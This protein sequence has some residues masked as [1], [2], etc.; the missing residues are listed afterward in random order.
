MT[1]PD[2]KTEDEKIQALFQQN[3]DQW[4]DQQQQQQEKPAG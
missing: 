4:D 2:T 3:S 1:E